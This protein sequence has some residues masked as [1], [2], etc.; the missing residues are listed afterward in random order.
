MDKLSISRVRPSVCRPYF[1]TPRW[2]PVN[3]LRY[4]TTSRIYDTSIRDNGAPLL[5]RI[6]L[7]RFLITFYSPASLMNI[8]NITRVK[9]VIRRFGNIVFLLVVPPGENTNCNGM[10]VHK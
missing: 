6:I 8:N 9:T 7:S 2:Q 3:N 5:S 4:L 10:Y 1:S